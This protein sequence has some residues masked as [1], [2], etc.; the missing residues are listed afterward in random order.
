MSVKN[1]G[2]RGNNDYIWNESIQQSLFLAHHILILKESSPIM[3]KN[4]I[5]L[6]VASCTSFW[7]I[8]SHANEQGQMTFTGT[9]LPQCS[10]TRL[11]DTPASGNSATFALVGNHGSITTVCNTGSS[12]S[13]TVDQA[14]IRLS[15]SNPKIRFTS[16][17]TGIYTHAHQGIDYQSTATFNSHNITS[18]IGDTAKIEVD[19]PNVNPSPVIVYASLTPQ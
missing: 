1:V 5:I 18:P 6:A 8:P 10:F 14:A 3:P 2:S 12:L 4:L 15:N 9:V 7:A 11:N 16:G 17:G 19:L 13:V